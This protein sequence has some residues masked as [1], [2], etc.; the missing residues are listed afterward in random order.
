MVSWDVAVMAF[1]GISAIGFLI[2]DGEKRRVR[3]IQ[4]MR[5]CLL[6]MNTLIRYEQPGMK[7]LLERIDLR[8]TPQDRELTRL[9]HA[10][11]RQCGATLGERVVS[12]FTMSN[13][14]N[15]H[16]SSVSHPLMLE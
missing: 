4:A 16:S 10:C 3:Y 6:R 14:I 2:A 8:A 15:L 12:A 13:K 7:D 1:V 5:R 9:L 11:W